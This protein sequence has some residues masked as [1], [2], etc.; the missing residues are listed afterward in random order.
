MKDF[1]EKTWKISQKLQI[2]WNFE[3]TVFELT[4]PDLYDYCS[5][6]QKSDPLRKSKLTLKE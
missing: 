6:S 1:T 5:T 3:L 2:N 4:I